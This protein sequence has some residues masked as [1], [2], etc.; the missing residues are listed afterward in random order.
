[1]PRLDWQLWFA[2]L[3]MPEREPWCVAFAERLLEGSR[4]VLGLLGA[5]PFPRAPPRYLR[6]R[7]FEY[8]FT[9]AAER[10]AT[11]AWWRRDPAGTYL[12]PLML[13]DGRLMLAPRIP[14]AAP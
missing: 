6:A 8:R 14:D 9:N 4:P 5:N 3:A 7:L 10:R 11:G 1:M 13:A 2:A 12:P